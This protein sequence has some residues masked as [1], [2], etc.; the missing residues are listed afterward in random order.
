M[1]FE[2]AGGSSGGIGRFFLGLVMLIGGGYMLLDSIHV[3]NNFGLGTRMF[4][5]GGFGITSGFILIPMMFGIGMVFYNAK[6]PIGWLLFIGALVALIFGVISS[7]QFTMGSMSLFELL[8]ILVL[9]VGG[10][11]LLLASLKDMSG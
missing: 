3:H 10:I 5:Y 11:G 6:N 8:V 9:F 2:G 4:S 7:I 1:S